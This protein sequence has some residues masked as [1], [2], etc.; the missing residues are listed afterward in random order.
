MAGDKVGNAMIEVLKI[1]KNK[2]RIVRGRLVGELKVDWSIQNLSEL[3][4]LIEFGLS[5]ENELPS[6][7]KAKYKNMRVYEGG[8]HLDI[9]DNNVGSLGL[10]RIEDHY[11]D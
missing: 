4:R 7:K 2:F 11:V 5:F 3:R 9:I 1:E 8:N 6:L 10:L